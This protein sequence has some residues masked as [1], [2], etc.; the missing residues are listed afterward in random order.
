MQLNFYYRL[1]KRLAIL[2]QL[3]YHTAQILL[4]RAHP[5]RFDYD[6]KMKEMQQRHIYEVCGLVASSRDRTIAHVSLHCL[7]LAADYLET[8][9][10][11]SEVMTILDTIVKETPWDANSIKERL[12]RTWGWSVPH[13]DTVDPIQMHNNYYGLDPALQPSKDRGLASTA[14][15]P[16]LNAGDFSLENHPY[17]GCYVPPHHVLDHYPHVPYLA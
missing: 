16:F 14:V 4:A 7:A 2:A 6:I 3:F 17:Q 12:T 5:M 8:H 9:T 13:H 15:N 10:A 1:A 11:Q